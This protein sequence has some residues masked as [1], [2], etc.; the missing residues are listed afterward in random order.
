M[1]LA[2]PGF[3]GIPAR[4][5]N[6][7]ENVA[8]VLKGNDR[9]SVISIS[10]TGEVERS[11]CLGLS[12]SVL[13]SLCVFLSASVSPSLPP[14]ETGSHYVVQDGTSFNLPV[15]SSRVYHHPPL[16][17][18]FRQHPLS[19]CLIA[20]LASSRCWNKYWRLGCLKDRNVLPHCSEAWKCNVK[21]LVWLVCSEDGFAGMHVD[22]Q[23]L[24]VSSHNKMSIFLQR[25]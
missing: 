9:L 12:L 21:M 17:S 15:S 20:L 6:T 3:W 11:W 1:V 22:G 4:A 5:S 19:I 16:A 8:I 10:V 25:N 2:T 24:L 14:A 7:W 18:S 13:L 23:Q